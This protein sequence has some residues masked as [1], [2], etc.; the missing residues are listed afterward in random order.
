MFNQQELQVLIGGTEEPVDIDDLKRNCIYGGVYD[1]DHAVVQRFW[2]ASTLSAVVQVMHVDVVLSVDVGHKII[3]SE[4][5]AITTAV[6]HQL[7]SASSTVRRLHSS[8]ILK[9]ALIPYFSR[10][11]DSRNYTH[12]S[13]FGTPVYVE[14]SAPLDLLMNVHL[15]LTILASRPAAHV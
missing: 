12:I 14:I 8:T 3:E 6:C 15:S 4:R 9:H 10:K 5:T 13:R 7:Q 2:R 11:V 1:S